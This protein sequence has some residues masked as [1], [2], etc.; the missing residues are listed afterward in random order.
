MDLIITQ[1]VENLRESSAALQPTV[2][3]FGNG[4][5]L[6]SADTLKKITDVMKVAMG[7]AMV[8]FP[9]LGVDPETQKELKCCGSLEEVA[10]KKI[11]AWG[12]ND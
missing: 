8:Q 7:S 9:H 2:D 11:V 3:S 10:M 1:H 5:P 6:K 12:V 4:G